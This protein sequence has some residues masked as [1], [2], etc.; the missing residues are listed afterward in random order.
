VIGKLQIRHGS[1]LL[2]NFQ[3]SLGYEI[4]RQIPWNHFARKNIGYL[5]A[6]EQHPDFIFDFDDDNELSDLEWFHTLTSSKLSDAQS[7]FIQ[8]RRHLLNPYIYFR[9]ATDPEGNDVFTWPRGF[10]LPFIRDPRTYEFGTTAHPESRPGKLALVQSLADHDPDVD[11]IYRMTGALPFNFLQKRKLLTVPV[12]TFVPWNA[13]ATLFAPDAYWSLLLPTSVHGRVSDIWRSYIGERLF[14]EFNLSLAFASSFVKQFRNPHSYF[15]DYF[16]EKPLYENASNLLDHLAQIKL[17]SDMQD[18]FLQQFYRSVIQQGF[19]GKQDLSLVVGWIRDLAKISY[20]WPGVGSHKPQSFA[21][22]KEKIKDGR[23]TKQP[24]QKP[25][26]KITV[27]HVVSFA[28]FRKRPPRH[29]YATLLRHTPLNWPIRLHFDFDPPEQ[30]L[31]CLRNSSDPPLISFEK[32][33]EYQVER[34]HEF[35]INHWKFYLDTTSTFDVIFLVD[36]DACLVR[37]FTPKNVFSANNT[38]VSRLLIHSLKFN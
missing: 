23:K 34:D 33:G 25:A 5:Y 36:D 29:S 8:T 24:W 10:P 31:A 12:E 22:E 27:E 37:D 3:L 14:W 4:T 9:P 2:A 32:K 11:A 20:T 6:I 28:N 35:E 7:S 15:K 18:N 26:H 16:H 17:S 19:L 30:Y 13:Q 1:R 38:L 21:M